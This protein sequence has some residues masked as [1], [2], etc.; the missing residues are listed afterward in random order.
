MKSLSL[1]KKRKRQMNTARLRT[2]LHDIINRV[3][4]DRVLQAVHTILSAQARDVQLTKESM[5]KMLEASE[6][7]I[8]EG[9]VI[10]HQDLKKEMLSWSKK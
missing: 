2:E 9:R 4:D 3:T 1:Q 10:D 7:D 6:N 5:D 8:Q